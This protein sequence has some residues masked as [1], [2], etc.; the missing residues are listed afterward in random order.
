[1]LVKKRQ[2]CLGLFSQRLDLDSDNR[3]LRH[4]DRGSWLVRALPVPPSLVCW[5]SAQA[6]L[7]GI[8]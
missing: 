3:C 6:V 4:F 8:F 7:P 5:D 1:M 2:V